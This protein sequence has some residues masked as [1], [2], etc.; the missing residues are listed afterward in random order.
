MKTST[1]LLAFGLALLGAAP[2][3]AQPAAAPPVAGEVT[4]GLAVEEVKLVAVGLSAKQQIL[5]KP[6]Y[7]ETAEKIGLVED[8]IVTPE[9]KVSVAIIGVGGFLGIAEHN[10][11]IPMRQL[12]FVG[13]KFTLPGATK[14]ALKS[15]PA[16]KYATA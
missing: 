14:A 9:G 10:V 15:L 3:L 16:F 2:A 11:A 4:L 5:G 7:N 8:V 6:V 1:L 13:D 12:K